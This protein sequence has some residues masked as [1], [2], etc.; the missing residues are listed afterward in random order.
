M[1]TYR[2][3]A[4]DEA[5]GA[6]TLLFG[7]AGPGMAVDVL[8]ESVAALPAAARAAG[9]TQVLGPMHHST[10]HSYRAVLGGSSGGAFAGDVVSH[11][12]LPEVLAKAGYAVCEEYA[13]VTISRAAAQEAV[14][15]Y[16]E[17]VRGN[18]TEMTLRHMPRRAF[19]KTIETLYPLVESTFRRNRLYSP[20]ALQEFQSLYAPSVGASPNVLLQL[21]E[22]DGHTVGFALFLEDERGLVLKTLGRLPGAELRALGVAPERLGTVLALRALE[23]F[24]ST[25]HPRL[26][27]ALMHVDNPS[28]ARTLAFGGEVTSRYGLFLKRL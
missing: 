19:A 5:L 12:A 9:C 6:K 8:E 25:A 14:G 10:W 27:A 20:I 23:Y 13:S 15:R 1:T 4:I 11:A 21:A 3:P 2:N 22:V 28:Y 18:E 16:A 17:H 24:L 26:I 7:Q